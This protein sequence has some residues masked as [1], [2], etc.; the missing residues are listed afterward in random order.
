[1]SELN[2]WNI[3]VLSGYTLSAATAAVA[4]FKIKGRAV[5]F[6][7]VK[8]RYFHSLF[9]LFFQQKLGKLFSLK[10]IVYPPPT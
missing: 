5:L 9:F 4:A 2:F 8:F 3:S 7:A 10:D 1:M 6:L